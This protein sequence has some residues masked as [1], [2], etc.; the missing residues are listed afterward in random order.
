M[1]V[2]TTTT[3][4]KTERQV[5]APG[6]SWVTGGSAKKEGSALYIEWLCTPAEERVPRTKQAFADLLGVS[7]TTLRD[8]AQDVRF[9]SEMDERMRTTMR[10]EK[11]PDVLAALFSQA[12]DT[13]NSRSVA[14]AKVWLDHMNKTIEGVAPKDMAEMSTDELAALAFAL[15]ESI[16]KPKE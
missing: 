13:E 8:W 3:K 1:S 15:L 12:T 16:G 4:R 10:I 5:Y 14:A 2:A 11:A 7:T 9:R 6:E